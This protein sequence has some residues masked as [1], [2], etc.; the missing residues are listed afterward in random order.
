M[1]LISGTELRAENL[2]FSDMMDYT[3]ENNPTVLGIKLKTVAKSSNC[4]R[5]YLHDSLRG[6]EISKDVLAKTDFFGDDTQLLSLL[7]GVDDIEVKDTLQEEAQEEAQ[8]EDMTVFS[9][10]TQPTIVEESVETVLQ[11]ASLEVEEVDINIDAD[12]FIVPDLGND[13]DKLKL[14]L[15][16]KQKIIE[17]RNARIR[18]LLAEREESFSLQ[19]AQ[20]LEMR[21]L[22]EE[23]IKE[24][25]TV[26]D[27]L[28]SELSKAK[29]PQEME[30]FLKFGVYSQNPKAMVKE[31][32]S[33]DE[34][35]EI[36]PK[37]SDMYILAAGTG[38]SIY[39]MLKHVGE[40]MDTKQDILFVDMTGDNFMLSKY[41]L[42]QSEKS[43]L[44][45]NNKVF[46]PSQAVLDLNGIKL[47]PSSLFNDIAL[48]SLDWGRVIKNL[49]VCA[50][51]KPI[52]LLFN[53]VNSFSVKYTVSKLATW[54]ELYVFMKCTPITLNTTTQ[55]DLRFIPKD[56]VKLIALDYTDNFKDML[57][58]I[59]KTYPLT[60]FQNTV[61][62]GRLGIGRK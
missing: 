60:A 26:I 58:A 22:Y 36:G 62:W 52:V 31:G 34:L 61:D 50:N 23:R 7:R 43:F 57:A 18:E 37:T 2:P 53:N 8:E 33:Q 49:Q 17:Q 46:T 32:L 24:A 6:I 12:V 51:G 30:G 39:S 1:I 4:F 27:G 47:I 13:T 29:I 40:L 59:A 9:E 28:K 42:Q 14:Q 15:D 54:G 55:A 41:R 56:R 21:N 3:V 5:V 48:L 35:N 25:N 20:L 19:E 10:D 45:L 11:E 44:A 38:A 16:S